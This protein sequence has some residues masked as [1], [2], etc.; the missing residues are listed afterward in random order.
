MKQPETKQELL[1][2]LGPQRSALVEAMNFHGG[3]A[4]SRE[5]REYA[6]VPKGSM[7]HHLSTLVEWEVF[8]PVG[9]TEYAGKGP[10]AA[11]YAFTAKGQAVADDVH[12]TAV[13]ADDVQDLREEVAALREKQ[14]AQ[15]ERYR[16][17]RTIL[18]SI[19]DDLAKIKEN[20]ETP[21]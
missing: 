5:L 15:D 14:A 10:G 6:D 16:E 17:L 8:E 20:G 1:D 13:T 18:D 12:T 3:R 4:N 2:R 11:V 19:V 21:S 9:E 7:Q